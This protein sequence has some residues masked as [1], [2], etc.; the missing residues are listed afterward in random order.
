MAAC[1]GS[2]CM[3]WS[4]LEHVEPSS[5]FA[6]VPSGTPT[7]VDARGEIQ[8]SLTAGA[9]GAG[10]ATGSANRN[11]NGISF[12]TGEQELVNHCKTVFAQRHSILRCPMIPAVTLL[13]CEH[14]RIM[15]KA[16]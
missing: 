4:K 9:D 13:A 2:D 3:L 7:V 1:G 10:C 8:N 5:G 14:F 6:L 11:S 16:C 15:A 12:I